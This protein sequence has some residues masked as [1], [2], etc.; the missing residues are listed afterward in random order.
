MP[1][2]GFHTTTKAGDLMEF[3]DDEKHWGARRIRVG[4][5]WTQDELRIKSNE[6]LNK[7]WFVLL[8]ERNMLLTMEEA[9]KQEC[10]R[11]PNEERIDKVI[12]VLRVCQAFLTLRRLSSASL[13]AGNPSF[14]ESSF[15]KSAFWAAF[16]P[17]FCEN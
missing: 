7:L 5:S 8:K 9:Y 6:D 2:G 17:E 1:I 10:L 4:R 13:K 11:L 3:F 15:S 12:G 14:G 16:Q